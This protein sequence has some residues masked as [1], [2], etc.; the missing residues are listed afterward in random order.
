MTGEIARVP[1]L[2]FTTKGDH[3]G[4][5]VQPTSKTYINEQQ[6]EKLFLPFK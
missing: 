5:P 1:V 4:T 3:P 2:L 6:N